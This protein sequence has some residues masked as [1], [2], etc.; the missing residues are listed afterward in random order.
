[1]SSNYRNYK[2]NHDS[3]CKENDYRNNNNKEKNK[4]KNNK[5]DV[6]E[7]ERNQSVIDNNKNMFEKNKYNSRDYMDK[8]YDN[9]YNKKYDDKYDKKCDD[10][11]DKNYDER[12]NKNYDD[13]YDKNYDERYNKNY[14]YDERYNKNYDDKYDKNYDE[15]YNKNYDDK[16]D[17]K[18]DK[19]YDD[20]Y[21]KKY[22]D[23]KDNEYHKGKRKYD[24]RKH[25]YVSQEKDYNRR[26]N[27][28][29]YDKYKECNIE[30]NNQH[31]KI[32]NHYNNN[33]SLYNKIE[34]RKKRSFAKSKEDE[35]NK[36][37]EDLSEDDK[38]KDYSSASE[39][40]FY[41]YKKRKNNT[42]EYKDDKDYT[43]YDNKFRKIRNIDD[44]LEMKPNILL[45]RFIFI[46]K[47]VDNISEDEID[48]LIRNI[49]IN[50]AFSLPVNIYINK[51]SF[52]SIKD[53]LFVK[54]NLEFL[55]NNSYFNIIQQKIQSNFLLENRINDD[56]CCIIEFPSDEASGKLFSLYEKDNCIEIKN[57]IS[58]IFPLFKL[59]NK[60]KN[61]EE[62]TGSNKVS[63]WYCSACNFLNFSRRTACHFCK[64]PK[65]SD[66]KLVDKETSTISTFI[67]NNINHQ[68]NNLY[69]INNKNL[70]NNM[71]VDKG[72][73]NHMLSDPLNMQKVYVYNN[74][75]D[76]YENILNDTYKDANNN[77][78]NNNNNNNNDN[79]YN[80]NNNNNNNSKNNNYN[81]NYNS[82]YNRGNENNHLKLSNNNIF[83]SYNPFHKFNEDSQNYENINK[84]II[85]DDQNTNML[86][87]KNMDG[88]ILIKDFIQFLNVTFDKNDVSCIYLFNDIK[89]S[90][91]KK[92]FCFIEFY[93]INMAKKVMNNM[94]KNYYL[95]FQDNY[96]KLDYVY[97]KE[98]QYFFNCIQMAKLDISKSSA[99]VVKNNIPYF[100]F[101]VNYFEAVVHMNIHCYTY[102][103]MWSS[104][105]IILKKGK[106]ELSEF[107]FDYNSQYYYHPLYQLY[108]DNNTKYYM[109]LS[110]GYYIWEDG[111]KCL[112]RVYLDNLGENVY[113][114]ENYDKK[115]SLMDASKNK[116]HEETHQQARINDD[117][118]Y[119]NIS[120]NNII[121]GH[122]LEQKL[123]NYKIEKENEKKNNNENV[124]LNKISSFVEKAKEIALASKKN[125]EQM[126]MNDNNLSILEKKNKEIIKKHF[127]TDS[128]DDEDEENDN[129]ND[130]DEHDDDHDNEKEDNDDELNNVSIKNKDNISDI[131][132]I[133]K[134]SNDDHNN[135]QRID[136][137]SYY[138]Y[139]KN[140][141]LSD[142]ISNNINN[143]IP[144]QNNNNDMKK[145]YTNVS[146]NSFNNSNIYNNNN[147][148][149]NNNDEKDVISEQSE[150]NINICFICLRK[151][152]NEEM[153]Q[154]HIDVS[155]L[156]KKN[157][158]ILSDPVLSN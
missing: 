66:A 11:Y 47:L 22:Q 150:K 134:Q 35:R 129:D 107:F 105:I 61:V 88:N 36:S 90:S 42:Y 112:L 59:K 94:E 52:F 121:N 68:E 73:Y 25:S 149:I 155:N 70:Y 39:S 24:E 6:F 81:N 58:Y 127:T 126:N 93:N 85:C 118:K 96:L 10:K 154:R 44:I 30:K 23:K 32:M 28:E 19:R 53:E 33:N 75:E 119:D 48:E 87:L 131:N 106:P 135:K 62:K 145:G 101:F 77:I 14:D 151:F 65:T 120:N 116:E 34:Y 104:Q 143:N 141:K 95:N 18:Y 29:T 69:L 84:E 20:K 54:E 114:R 50:N 136:N 117:H 92:G 76:N 109:S 111:L 152:L 82:N 79:D 21:D 13:K 115:F 71:H 100:N 137:S 16:Y 146:N 74:M 38:N 8:K 26:N 12:Y 83:F 157:V 43:S 140:V 103:L 78:S 156:H 3:Y 153:L 144:Y 132:I 99:T 86:I 37:E 128:A 31:T 108:F 63:D 56:Q 138:D 67:K 60:G 102:F 15:R 45:S 51:L 125:I 142:N 5:R 98:K 41:K 124:I 158:E 72:T 80:N 110:K 46:Y 148:H 64:A 89:G 4:I 113:E 1:M 123:S 91:K 133:E 147:E 17:K 49:S 2:N 9:K 7:R 55:K 40:N 27:S 122:M 130:N 57:N 139:K 97:E